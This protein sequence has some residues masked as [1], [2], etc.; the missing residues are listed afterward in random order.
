MIA[1]APPWLVGKVFV[2][3]NT[4]TISSPIHVEEGNV[5]VGIVIRGIVA[6]DVIT[7]SS[8]SGPVLISTN[9]NTHPTR[10]T[11]LQLMKGTRGKGEGG[12]QSE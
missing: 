3:V 8:I 7:V 4:A 6:D 2:L 1:S 9:I 10:R 11:K 12:Y 5:H